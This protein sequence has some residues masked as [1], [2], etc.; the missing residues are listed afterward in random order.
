MQAAQGVI[1][2]PLEE[3]HHILRDDL[4]GTVVAD[5]RILDAGPL[6]GRDR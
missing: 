6:P 1:L 2:E 3:V 5:G 4:D